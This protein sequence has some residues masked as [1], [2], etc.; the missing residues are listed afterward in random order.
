MDSLILVRR[1]HSKFLIFTDDYLIREYILNHRTNARYYLIA[2]DIDKLVKNSKDGQDFAEKL[3]KYRED[4]A[5]KIFDFWSSDDPIA[6]DTR[7]PNAKSNQGSEEEL[8]MNLARDEE[9]REFYT[10]YISTLGTCT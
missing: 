4:N 6:P 5:E 8:R 3:E 2:D 1:G 9:G 10:L 7:N